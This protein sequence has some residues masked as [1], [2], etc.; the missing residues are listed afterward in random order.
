L[1]LDCRTLCT[2]D[3]WG[4]G[5]VGALPKG[6]DRDTIAG[7]VKMSGV[8]FWFRDGKIFSSSSSLTS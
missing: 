5:A 3:V 4:G 6:P 1:A 7:P 8:S 2:V